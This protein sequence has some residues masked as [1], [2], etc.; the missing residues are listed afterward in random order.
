ML[1]DI[2]PKVIDGKD[3]TREEAA[4]ALRRLRSRSK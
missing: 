3:L 1:K 2:L 4:G